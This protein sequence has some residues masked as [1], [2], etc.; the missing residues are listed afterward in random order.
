ME[1]LMVF[2]GA[3]ILVIALTVTKR[4]LLRIM[5]SRRSSHQ[6]SRSL[7]GVRRALARLSQAVYRLTTISS[8]K[9]N[10]LRRSALSCVSKIS[11][12]IPATLSNRTIQ[13]SLSESTW[14]EAAL[15]LML[16]VSDTCAL[17]TMFFYFLY[18]LIKVESK[19]V[20]LPHSLTL[21]QPFISIQLIY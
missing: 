9:V 6:S 18:Y 19:L 1:I 8:R 3:A 14:V 10:C 7:M 21:S 12:S 15:S 2:L 11:S 16:P 4:A 20:T 13:P 17:N 5:P